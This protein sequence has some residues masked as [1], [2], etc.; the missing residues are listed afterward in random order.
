M[1]GW[2]ISS[3]VLILV[4]VLIRGVLRGRMSLRLQYALWALVLLRLL[5]PFSLF[6]SRFSVMTIM[7]EVPGVELMDTAR[8]LGGIEE[9]AFSPIAPSVPSSASDVS[10]TYPSTVGSVNGYYAGDN[11]RAFPTEVLANATAEEFQQLKKVMRVQDI[12][13]PIW[14]VGSALIGAYFLITNL[15]FSAALRRSR[16]EKD[17]PGSI[18]PIY[19]SGAIP[20]PCLFGLMRPAVYI[21]PDCEAK[22][23]S[24]RHVLAHEFTHYRH[25][26]NIWAIL[27]CMAL[28]LHWY[29]PLVWWAAVLSKRDGELACDEG[30]IRR[31]GEKERAP[32]GHTLIGMTCRRGDIGALAHAATTMTGSKAGI[33]ERIMLIAKKPKMAV[34]TLIAVILIAA[35]AVGCTF[36][37]ADS[38]FS[39]REARK[40]ALP[41]AEACAFNNGLEIAEKGKVTRPEGHL[42]EAGDGLRQQYVSVKYSLKN[43]PLHIVV[44]FAMTDEKGEAYDEPLSATIY[45]SKDGT[46]IIEDPS[47]VRNIRLWKAGYENPTVGEGF[48]DELL[49]Y[50]SQFEYGEYIRHQGEI[51]E[52]FNNEGFAVYFKDGSS[53]VVGLDAAENHHVVRPELESW[54]EYTFFSREIKLQQYKDSG[55]AV[56]EDMLQYGDAVLDEAAKLVQEDIDHL[57]SLSTPFAPYSIEEAEI[58]SISEIP[59]GA[60]A[61]N[62]SINMFELEYRLR[63]DKPENIVMNELMKLEDGW[64]INGSSGKKYI[65]LLHTNIDTWVHLATLTDYELEAYRETDSVHSGNEYTTACMMLY[66]DYMEKLRSSIDFADSVASFP[67]HVLDSIIHCAEMFRQDYTRLGT[68]ISA[69]E[70][71]D[72]I[73]MDVHTTAENGLTNVMYQLKYRLQPEDP[74]T[75]ILAGGMEYSDGWLIE[76]RYL[77]CEMLNGEPT[78]N[79]R[80]FTPLEIQER[81]ALPQYIEA[82]GNMYTAARMEAF[83]DPQYTYTPIPTPTAIVGTNA[84][85]GCYLHER[86]RRIWTGN[87]WLYSDGIP[88]ASVLNEPYANQIPTESYSP[89]LSYGTP[90]RLIRDLIVYDENMQPLYNDPEG[91]FTGTKALRWLS[92]G[93]YYCVF[94]VSGPPGQYIVEAGD[95]EYV[96]YEAIFRLI[97]DDD[98]FSAQVF[99]P[100]NLGE[101]SDM[102]Y[103]YGDSHEYYFDDTESISAVCRILSTAKETSYDRDRNFRDAI[104]LVGEDST[105]ALCLAVDG[106]PWLYSDGRCWELSEENMAALLDILE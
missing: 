46:P 31:L 44:D 17:I 92:P 100:G 95:S 94:T 97:V 68:V 93:T 15:H 102:Y 20:T 13:I 78:I 66:A 10:S 87:S 38:N 51:G 71:T 79:I 73:P 72:L 106:S 82:Y 83:I 76:N 88:L 43:S 1:I 32:Y 86:A 70:V 37:G 25:G 62:F 85:I 30:A 91:I 14:L 101:Y 41:L 65:V 49:D 23:D 90:Y 74:S 6:E 5:L 33:K 69:I 77:V 48:E 2:I 18:I 26:D 34:Y 64:L 4:I 67:Q 16:R 63:P 81:Y 45:I 61:N 98:I 56:K 75:V 3:S 11:D 22:E 52:D 27:S 47:Q 36:S 84:P 50:L 19:V 57:L 28:A 8:E 40:E 9:I 58:T 104:Y 55:V 54:L 39:D 29:N 96:I 60:A 12:L 53:L 80:I 99:E 89:R 42:L 59:T 21:T 103:I 7:S 35:A 105:M 24:L